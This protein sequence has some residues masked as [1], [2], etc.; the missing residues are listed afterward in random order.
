[1]HLLLEPLQQMHLK[2]KHHPVIYLRSFRPTSTWFQ[3]AVQVTTTLLTSL[4]ETDTFTHTGIRSECL[5]SCTRLLLSVTELIL[6]V[7]AAAGRA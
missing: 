4:T 1:M 3:N 7:V 2:D 5:C 6:L